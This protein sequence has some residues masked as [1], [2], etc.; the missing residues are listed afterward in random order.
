M[1]DDIYDIAKRYGA[2]DEEIDELQRREIQQHLQAIARLK[3]L[4][5]EWDVDVI[6]GI[7]GVV[8]CR[9]WFLTR[10]G[11]RKEASFEKACSLD[12]ATRWIEGP[13]TV[14]APVKH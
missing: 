10:N 8:L 1:T 3:E 5:V 12:K 9:D 14:T 13:I 11:K 7:D 2:S 6:E 4:A